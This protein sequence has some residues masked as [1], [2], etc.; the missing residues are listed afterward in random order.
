MHESRTIAILAGLVVAAA[1]GCQP[2][3]PTP[4][5]AAETAAT[6]PPAI[7]LAG[8][9]FDTPE[10]VL[11]DAEAD[12]YLVSNI[13]GSPLDKDDDGFISRVS[14]EGEVIALK[15]IDGGGEDVVL[16][17]PKGMAIAGDTLYVTDIDVVRMFDRTTGA[18]KGEV[19][20]EGAT[21]LNDVAPAPGGGVYV[22]DSG[23]KA[24]ASGFE[25]SGS[26]AVYRLGADGTLNPLLKGADLPAPNGVAADGDR[27]LVVTF[28]AR[29]LFTVEGD[30]R[31]VLAEL[32]AGSLDGLE[33]LP[34][35][36]WAVSSWEAQAV[37]AGPLGGPFEK[38]LAD[39]P[40]PADIGVDA[41]RGRL[42]VPKF[43]ENEVLI[44]PLAP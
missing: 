27:V 5:T 40:A 10:S 4:E 38:L 23:L 12:V 34:D 16:H 41:K 15:W 33:K 1:I 26:A 20:V 25:P 37:Y 22:T 13:G 19:A 35:G 11:H 32:P 29:E 8:V 17:A 44:V 7:R 43:T 31:R 3:A 24:G 18:A 9:G 42:L 21:F 28:G 36:R 39:V 2:Q 6:P 30:G 14:P